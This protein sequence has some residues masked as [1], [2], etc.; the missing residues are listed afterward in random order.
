MADGAM[1]CGTPTSPNSRERACHRLISCLCTNTVPPRVERRSACHSSY[2]VHKLGEILEALLPGGR[3]AVITVVLRVA[4]S[5]LAVGSSD[6]CTLGLVW[7]AFGIGTIG[8]G[9]IVTPIDSLRSGNWGADQQAY[10]ENM[11]GDRFHGHHFI[12][13]DSTD[14]CFMRPAA[15]RYGH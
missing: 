12:S 9:T 13:H 15:N 7:G 1:H 6:D 3:M 5:R 10:D 8:E 4:R 14:P 11:P 2:S